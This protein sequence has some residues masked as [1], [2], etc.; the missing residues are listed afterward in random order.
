MSKKVYELVILPGD[1]IGEEV[2]DQALKVLD[3]VSRTVKTE[4]HLSKFACGG[5]FFLEHGSSD[6]EEGAEQACA[7]LIG[8]AHADRVRAGQAQ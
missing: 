7:E 8:L 4:F 2:M 3:T 5:K 1:G 6:W